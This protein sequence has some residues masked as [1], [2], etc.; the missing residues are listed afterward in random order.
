MRLNRKV[1]DV[2]KPRVHFLSLKASGISLK[3]LGCLGSPDLYSL[4]YFRDEDTGLKSEN[5]LPTIRTN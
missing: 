1:E 2:R 4:L 3:Y 5:D